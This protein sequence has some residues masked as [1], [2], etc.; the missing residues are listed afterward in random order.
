MVSKPRID[1]IMSVYNG[2]NYLKEAIQSVLK[3]TYTNF[4]FIIVDDGSNDSSFDIIDSFEDKRIE[5][6]RNGRSEGLTKRMNK[7]FRVAQGKYVARQDA[8]DVSLPSRFESQ[9][10]FLEKHPEVDVLGTGIYLIDEEGNR[11]G[12]RTTHP[13][14][15]RQIFLERN[16]VFHGS[17]MIRRDAL[18]AVGGYNELFKYS[19]DYDLWLRLAK[20]HNIRNLQTPLYAFRIHKSSVS[21]SKTREQILFEIVARK[22]AKNE[23][24]LDGELKNAIARDGIG[25]IFYSLTAKEKLRVYRISI[26]R[27]ISGRLMQTKTG[28]TLLKVY[29]M[30]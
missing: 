25:S 20:E 28:R 9:V 6:I 4:K 10:D 15:S 21:L 12:E 17:A 5:V 2:E 27:G 29:H 14:P 24:V 13:S 30:V 23:L 18:E 26:K 8:D 1:V 11:S 19:Q 16:E 3:Q 22:I 7:A